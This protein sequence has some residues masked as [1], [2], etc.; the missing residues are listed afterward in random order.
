MTCTDCGHNHVTRVSKTP[1]R[2]YKFRGQETR[3][4]RETLCDLL[5]KHLHDPNAPLEHLRARALAA[6]QAQIHF[7]QRDILEAEDACGVVVCDED[8]VHVPDARLEGVLEE[9]GADHV[10]V[11]LLER[12]PPPRERRE[13]DVEV[14]RVIACVVPDRR[15]RARLEIEYASTRER[16]MDAVELRAHEELAVLGWQGGGALVWKYDHKDRNQTL[17]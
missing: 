2:L 11:L 4:V 16:V 1:S 8:A 3:L 12:A 14:V 5:I 15:D 7:V 13:P 10:E 9:R 17:A 6:E